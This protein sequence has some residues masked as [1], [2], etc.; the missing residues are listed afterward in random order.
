MD[1]YQDGGMT[2][3]TI[4]RFLKTHGVYISSGKI[5]DIITNDVEIFEQEKKTLSMQV[6]NPGSH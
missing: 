3:P 4:K 6:F 5:S 1:L 2:Q